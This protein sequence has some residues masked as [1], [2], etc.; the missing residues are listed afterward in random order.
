M[1]E[2]FAPVVQMEHLFSAH[3]LK[4]WWEISASLHQFSVSYR[5]WGRPKKRRIKVIGGVKVFLSPTSQKN[6]FM[7][8]E[9]E[10]GIL[11]LAKQNE[12]HFIYRIAQVGQLDARSHQK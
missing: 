12:G 11:V 4:P 6:A 8:L 1:C 5:R 3:F 10:R 2:D 7:A 9:G